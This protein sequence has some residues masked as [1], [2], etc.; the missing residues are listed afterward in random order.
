M[1]STALPAQA[2]P[3]T[4][5]TVGALDVTINGAWILDDN[6]VYP[7]RNSC[8][9]WGIYVVYELADGWASNFRCEYRSSAGGWLIWWYIS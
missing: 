7:N 5:M 1:V 2:A 9:Q 3:T 6:H 8:V 4:Q